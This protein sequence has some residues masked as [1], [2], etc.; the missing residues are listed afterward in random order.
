MI[1]S[2]T[3]NAAKP[4]RSSVIQYNLSGDKWIKQENDREVGRDWQ[5]ETMWRGKALDGDSCSQPILQ[6][7]VTACT[8][9]G[10]R[11]VWPTTRCIRMCL[12]IYRRELERRRWQEMKEDTRERTTVG[13]MWVIKQREWHLEVKKGESLSKK[14]SHYECYVSSSDRKRTH[15]HEISY[16]HRAS[17]V[18]TWPANRHGPHQCLCLILPLITDSLMHLVLGLGAGRWLFKA[19]QIRRTQRSILDLSVNNC[20][21][22][23]KNYDWISV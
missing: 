14:K 3:C 23:N 6:I 4:R 15:L 1:P 8:V 16:I 18:V 13:I 17:V 5:A 19:K 20:G 7:N 22:A 11:E 9:W 12:L 21:E 10:N 2:Y